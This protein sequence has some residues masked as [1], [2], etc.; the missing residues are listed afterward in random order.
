MY[1]DMDMD[2]DMYVYVYN[3]TQPHAHTRQFSRIYVIIIHIID[4][5]LVRFS[6]RY[7]IEQASVGGATLLML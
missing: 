2:M 6:C 4:C 7:K 1:M 3:S 5:C